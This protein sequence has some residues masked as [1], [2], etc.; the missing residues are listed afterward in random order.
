MGDAEN[1]V[2]G[3]S[4]PCPRFETYLKSPA[5][6]LP[7]AAIQTLTRRP[8]ARQP[9]LPAPLEARSLGLGGDS[10]GVGR[11]TTHL[12]SWLRSQTTWLSTSLS[13]SNV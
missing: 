10:V 1:L 13:S 9:G 7:R 11:A 4:N 2:G 8:A 6:A 3:R 12:S 5:R